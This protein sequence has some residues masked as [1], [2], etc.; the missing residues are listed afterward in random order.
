MPVPA[1]RR[2]RRRRKIRASHHALEKINLSTCEKCK[3]PVLPHH[4]CVFC[5]YYKG[6]QWMKKEAQV[7]K[8]MR[9]KEKK[10]KAA[11]EAEP[12]AQEQ[13]TAEGNVK[14]TTVVSK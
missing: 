14:Q 6:K 4:V 5:G 10:E 3:K 9:K 11:V 8:K 1:K 12:E 13:E 2:A 7:L